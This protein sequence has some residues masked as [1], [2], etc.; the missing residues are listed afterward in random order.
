MGMDLEREKR[1]KTVL[2]QKDRVGLRASSH[3]NGNT[4]T[5]SP[6]ALLPLALAMPCVISASFH[7]L[8]SPPE[9]AT[10]DSAASLHSLDSPWEGCGGGGSMSKI[11]LLV[12][13]RES[14]LLTFTRHGIVCPEFAGSTELCLSHGVFES[15]YIHHPK[16]KILVCFHFGLLLHAIGSSNV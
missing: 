16:I 8:L 4:P 11:W 10:S 6:S 13:L 9:A 15:K 5:P 7:W 3:T 2:Y 12:L 1:K 14:T